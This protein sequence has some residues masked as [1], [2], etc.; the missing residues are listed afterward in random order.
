MTAK[1]SILITALMALCCTADAQTLKPSQIVS[2]YSDIATG[3]QLFYFKDTRNATNSPESNGDWTPPSGKC[4]M[5]T[6][7]SASFDYGTNSPA[8]GFVKRARCFSS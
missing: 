6:D 3:G 1:L 5:L 8:M 2:L 7:I 4:F